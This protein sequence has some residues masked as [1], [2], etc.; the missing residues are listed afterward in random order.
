MNGNTIFSRS[1]WGRNEAR[2][3]FNI[4]I[5]KGTL[6]SIDVA[7]EFWMANSKQYEYLPLAVDEAIVFV[8]ELSPTNNGDKVRAGLHH[9]WDKWKP[10]LLQNEPE[11]RMFR[12]IIV[13][14]GVYF[15]DMSSIGRRQLQEKL[16]TEIC[17]TIG[18]NS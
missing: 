1:A 15:K 7:K 18:A 2:A 12:A 13:N 14:T 5:S 3:A 17:N 4:G 10:V 8:Q 9:L 6:G 11:V 16:L